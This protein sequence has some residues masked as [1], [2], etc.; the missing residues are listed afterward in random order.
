MSVQ[1]TPTKGLTGKIS[2]LD[3]SNMK[4]KSLTD[5]LAADAKL[6]DEAQTIH[7][8]KQAVAS[9]DKATEEKNDS[10]KNIKTFWLNTKSTDTN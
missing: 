10:L 6:K 8:V 2:D 4:G 1:E 7:E 9:T 3:M 5:K